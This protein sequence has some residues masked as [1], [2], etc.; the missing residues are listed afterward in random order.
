[1]L[2]DIPLLSDF[3]IIRRQILIDEN[4]HH[5]NSKHRHH[6]YQPRDECLVIH[7]DPTKL[8]SSKYGPF[9]VEHI[10]INST[11]TIRHDPNTTERLSIRHIIVPFQR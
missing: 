10:H 8:K 2:L 1:M 7:F 9:T 3:Q 11:T 6:D 4:L 5:A